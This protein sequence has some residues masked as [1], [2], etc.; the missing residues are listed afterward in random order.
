LRIEINRQVLAADG[1]E[2]NISASNGKN[3]GS[4][5]LNLS[6]PDEVLPSIDFDIDA[7]TYDADDYFPDLVL[8]K[9]EGTGGLSDFIQYTNWFSDI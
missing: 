3:S 6:A 1:G 4:F 7:S 9:P 8:L 2:I 5:S